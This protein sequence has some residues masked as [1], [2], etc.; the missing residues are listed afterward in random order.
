MS[1][2]IQKQL[3]DIELE[4]KLKEVD[5]KWEGKNLPN[6]GEHL[7]EKALVGLEYNLKKQQVDEGEAEIVLKKDAKDDTQI[8]QTAS[9]VRQPFL[10]DL[11]KK[12]IKLRRLESLF[13]KKE[14][15]RFDEIAR[16]IGLNATLSA[17]KPTQRKIIINLQKKFNMSV[18]R[19]WKKKL[20]SPRGIPG[21]TFDGLVLIDTN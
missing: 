10:K 18:K 12:N 21:I 16:A 4:R 8:T 15:A 19:V 3:L 17:Y 20:S 13:I 6:S 1:K 9:L 2:N 14:S 7:N 5:K 11:G